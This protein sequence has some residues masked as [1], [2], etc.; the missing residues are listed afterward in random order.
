MFL[1]EVLSVGRHGYRGK[2]RLLA[3]KHRDGLW[4]GVPAEEIVMPSSKNESLN[5]R[6]L[7]IVE[8]DSD[9]IPV[10]VVNASLHLVD[11]LRDLALRVAMFDRQKAEIALTKESLEYQSAKLHQ[12]DQVLKRAE[13]VQ[14]TLEKKLSSLLEL[15]QDKINA[16]DRQHVA[17]TEAW[18]H[19]QYKEEELKKK[20]C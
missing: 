6:Q 20:L 11:C 4:K 17:L 2:A 19:L 10:L 15:A 9:R 16:A 14:Q 3:Q 5:D 18:K 13:E 8:L 7:V 12:R 1:A